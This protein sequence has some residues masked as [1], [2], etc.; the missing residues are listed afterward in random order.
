MKNKIIKNNLGFTLV[1]SLVAVGILSLSVLATFSAVSNG[2]QYSGITKDQ[3][4]AFYLIQEGME[5]IKNTRDE[6]ALNNIGGNSRTWLYG[7]SE[8][9]SDPCYFDTTCQLDVNSTGAKLTRCPGSW[10]TCS[11]LRSDNTTGSYGY[12]NAWTATTFRREISLSAV[13]GN[14]DEMLI[15]IQVSWVNRGTNYSLRVYQSLFNRQ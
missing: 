8:N 9:N 11:V 1:E 4:T 6:N 5:Y 3:I 2:L 7:I 10:G 13:A 14:T 15:T 12:N